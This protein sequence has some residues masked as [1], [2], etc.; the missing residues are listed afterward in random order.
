M[1]GPIVGGISLLIYMIRG[2]ELDNGFIVVLGGMIVVWIIGCI[3][4]RVA[5]TL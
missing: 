3:S 5:G 1:I 2:G 4:A